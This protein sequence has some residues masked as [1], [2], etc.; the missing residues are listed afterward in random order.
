M[1]HHSSNSHLTNMSDTLIDTTGWKGVAVTMNPYNIGL[2]RAYVIQ[3]GSG[4]DF[5][6][7]AYMGH[8]TSQN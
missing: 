7:A 3:Q 6:S 4:D 8:D 2:D 5:D 1:Q